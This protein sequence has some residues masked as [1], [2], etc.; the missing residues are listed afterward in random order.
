MIYSVRFGTRPMRR[1]RLRHTPSLTMTLRMVSNPLLMKVLRVFFPLAGELEGA[2]VP[3]LL[4]YER[5]G[6]FVYGG[7]T[8]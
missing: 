3:S 1:G 8:A 2:T 4:T 5:R 7:A 6:H